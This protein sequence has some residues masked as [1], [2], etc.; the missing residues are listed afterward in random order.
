MHVLVITLVDMPP[1]YFKGV[2]IQ[3]LEL[4]LKLLIRK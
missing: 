4:V 2:F 3:L 1:M